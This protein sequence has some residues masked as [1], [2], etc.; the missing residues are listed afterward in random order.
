MNDVAHHLLARTVVAAG[1][2][3]LAA[4][5]DGRQRAGALGVV[6]GVD[7]GQLAATA[8][9]GALDRLSVRPAPWP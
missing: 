7:E 8:V 1:A 3:A 2:L 6:E 4:A 5:A 9:V